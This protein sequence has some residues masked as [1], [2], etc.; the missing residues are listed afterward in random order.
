MSTRDDV[1]RWDRDHVWHPFTQA[2]EWE[3]DAP[4]VIAAAE[5]VHLID[6]D[7]RRYLD[8]VSSLWTNV[9]GHRHPVLDAAVR[10]QLDRVAHST[11]LGLGSVPSATLARR[12]VELAER[13]PGEGA[14]LTRVFYSDSGST[15]VEVAL[16]MAFQAQQQRGQT[17]RTR[18]AAL[19]NAYHGDT[20][21]A[22]SVGGIELFHGIYRP[23]LFPALRLPAPERPDP[24]AEADCL[25]AAERL[26]AEEGPRLAAL[27]VDPLVQGAAGMLRHSPAFLDRLFDLARSAGVLIIADEVAT[28]FG[29]TGT[30]FALEQCRHRPDLLCLAKGI[31]GG[32]LPLAVTMT[33]EAVYAAFRGPYAA[34][35]TFFHGHTYTANPLACAAALANLDLFADGSLLVSLP[36]KIEALTRALA[37]LPEP[38]VAERRQTGLMAGAL[39]RAPPRPRFAHE[40]C[41]RARRHGVI[42]RPLGDLIVF[43]PPLAMTPAQITETVEAVGRALTEAWAA[44]P[45]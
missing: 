20:L 24:D 14:P 33:T 11:L 15:A 10:D 25:R 30:M 41:L 12:L 40:V 42:V 39:L 37:A 8:G 1:L 38:W 7:G 5:G 4:L 17:E 29:R 45:P 27:V 31:T 13:L 43:M 32:Y 35:R 21:G 18:V 2:E 23:L 19:Q 3:A 28:G 22:V 34:L 26:F 9:H 16:K 36:E 6:L 44:G